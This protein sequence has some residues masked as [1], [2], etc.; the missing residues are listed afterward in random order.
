MSTG[1]MEARAHQVS[2]GAVLVGKRIARLRKL[3]KM[4][5]AELAR[6]VGYH[7]HTAIVM[8]EKGYSYPVMDKAFRLSEVLGIPITELLAVRDDE[9]PW[10]TPCQLKKLFELRY[11]DNGRFLDD[12]EELVAFMRE[13]PQP[14]S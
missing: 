6:E 3:R 10:L 9:R 14:A 8:L 2:D 4:T 1:T 7:G 5:Q 12:L 13:L 11:R